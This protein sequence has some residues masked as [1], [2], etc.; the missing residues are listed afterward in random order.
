[1]ADL[2]PSGPGL[3]Q[4]PRSEGIPIPPLVQPQA[5]VGS[6]VGPEEGKGTGKEQGSVDKPTS[7]RGSQQAPGPIKHWPSVSPRSPSYCACQTRARY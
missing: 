1:M 3:G 6:L 2:H 4:D 7:L 5:N